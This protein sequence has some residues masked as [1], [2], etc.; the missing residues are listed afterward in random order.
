MKSHA[1]YNNIL[2]IG[3]AWVGDMVMA[4]GLFLWLKKHHPHCNIDVLSMPW[5]LPI[6][7]RMP[8]IHNV[9]QSPFQHKRLQLASRIQMAK[10]L[11]NQYD[12]AILLRNSLKSA[13]IPF[14]A[15]IP[16][17]IGWKKEGRGL[18]L[19]DT[20]TLDP[21]KHTQMLQ[22]FI[23]LAA[24]P[25]I[26]LPEDLS[27]FFP[28]LS[29]DPISI[30][31]TL[32]TFS[33]EKH[34]PAIALCPGAEFGSAKRWPA[35]HYATVAKHYLKQGF[36]VWLLGSQKDSV[37]TQQIN[38]LCNNQCCDFAGKTNLLQ[39]MDL[40]S[41]SHTVVSN[42][43]GLMHIAAALQKPLVA[44]YGS[45]PE[46]FAPPLSKHAISVY[47]DLPCR[48]CKQRECPL[49]HHQCMQNLKPNQVIQAITQLNNTTQHSANCL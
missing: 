26:T 35:E 29:I 23:A 41:L 45:T 38:N 19:T 36:Q 6:L 43:S 14:I 13:L 8:E 20:R 17:R 7:Q 34:T 27:P 11:R 21:H 48:P 28:K 31:K 47:L 46:Y 39:A 2:I 3:P 40:I 10:L 9:I 18:L 25:G 24:E 15:K 12:T 33:I 44:I 49:Q 5:C 32:N 16:Q 1:T 22:K 42:D 4:H 30:Q 37:V